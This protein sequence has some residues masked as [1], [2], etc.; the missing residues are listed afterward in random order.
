MEADRICMDLHG[1]G[2]GYFGYPSSHFLPVSIPKMEAD[3]I[4]MENDLD[5]SD[6]HLRVSFLSDPGL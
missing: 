4:R 3:P 2:F 1:K 6:I 5:F